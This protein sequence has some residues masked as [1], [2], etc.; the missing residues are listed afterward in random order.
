MMKKSQGQHGHSGHH[1][2]PLEQLVNP[3]ARRDNPSQE[4]KLTGSVI[5]KTAVLFTL[6]GSSAAFLGYT[7][8]Q[9]VKNYGTVLSSLQELT[10]NGIAALVGIVLVV[11]FSALV[12]TLVRPAWLAGI[13]YALSA[14][15]LV[16][17]WGA[18]TVTLILSGVLFVFSLLYATGVKKKIGNQI[19]FSAHALVEGQ[20]LLLIVL[21]IIVSASFGIGYRQDADRRDFIFPP[22]LKEQALNYMKEQGK[23]SIEKQAPGLGE[24]EKAV[25]IEEGTKKL[26]ETWTEMENSLKPAA[27]YI[28]FFLALMIYMMVISVMPLIGL[29]LPVFYAA[30]FP[31]LRVTGF[32]GVKTENREVQELVLT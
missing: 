7:S 13:G 2:N 23:A 11:I 16:I 19:H 18:D 15:A 14:A 12:A 25:A 10:N 9:L 26:S 6:L 1:A 24:K 5:A 4:P 28:P 30:I 3:F 22:E 29:I 27:S 20:M 21:G 31:F 32:A 17:A 8:S